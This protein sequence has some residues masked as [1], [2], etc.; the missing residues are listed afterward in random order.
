MDSKTVSEIING[1]GEDRSQYFNAVAP[2]IFQTSNFSFDSV[3]EFRK[4]LMDESS[5]FL[6]SRGNNPTLNILSTKLAALDH[7]EDALVV[8]SGAGAIFV[9]ILSHVKAGDHIISVESPYSWAQKMMEH[10]L[11]RFDVTTTFVDGR[12]VENF[13]K[14]IRD[15][16]TLIYLESPNS[17]TFYLQDLAAV[18]ALAKK[19]NIL[20]I[21]DNSYATSLY[22]RP[23]DLGIDITVQSATKYINGHSDVVAGVICS[24][25]EIMDKIFHSEYLNLGIG[26]TP[27]NAWLILR[28]LR[29][30]PARLDRISKT[31]EKVVAFIK[32]RK[33][34]ER[35]SFPMDDDFPQRELARK[36]MSG[37]C[38]LFSF[39]MRTHEREQIRQF[40]EAL[41]LILMA[42]SWGGHESLIMPAIATIKKGEFDPE[43]EAHRRIRLYVGLE[44]AEDIIEDL[45]RGF[46]AMHVG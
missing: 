13:E 15:N 37:G 9:S 3:E 12:H 5:A 40:V 32:G 2:P 46:A 36:Q 7:A 6:Y 28:G 17:W 31:T 35:V 21:C 14:A 38:G 10:V 45:K 27:F 26:T 23:I 20:T 29:T 33:E 43:N 18:A 25:K 42:V 24:R 16:T 4:G 11:P 1:L 34:V 41:T 22:Q 8:N 30:L 39:I 44:D 19:D